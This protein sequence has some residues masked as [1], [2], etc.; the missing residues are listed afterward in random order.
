VGQAYFS[1]QEL[2]GKSCNMIQD[3]LHEERGINLNNYPTH[4]KR[5]TCVIRKEVE[6]NITKTTIMQFGGPKIEKKS[7]VAKDWVIDTEIPMFKGEDRKYIEDLIY[8][9][10]V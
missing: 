3:M 1:H 9:G 8:V 5:G 10:E 7:V 2:Q 6:K 4:Q